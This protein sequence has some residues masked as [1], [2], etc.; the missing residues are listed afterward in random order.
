V[1]YEVK[2]LKRAVM[3]IEDICRFLSQF[4]PGTCGRF[5]DELE[6]TLDNLMQNPYMYSEYEK[7]KAYRRIIIQKYLVFY[8][9]SKTAETVRVYRILHGQRDLE[10]LMN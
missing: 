5:L 3:D 10:N 4:Y 7:N 2:L 1:I 8:K 6:R 9:A